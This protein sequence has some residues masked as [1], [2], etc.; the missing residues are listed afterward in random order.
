ML[1]V[2]GAWF[3]INLKFVQSYGKDVGYAI[4]TYF[5][6]F[7]FFPIMAFNKDI[8]YIGPAGQGDIDEILNN[9]KSTSNQSQQDE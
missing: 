6:P 4:G 2:I 8:N 5:L 9:M 1:I 3:Y 7:I